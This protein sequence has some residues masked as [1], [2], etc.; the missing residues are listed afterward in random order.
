MLF[1]RGYGEAELPVPVFAQRSQ[2]PKGE[3]SE[4]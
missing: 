3:A 4:E 2:V 1:V